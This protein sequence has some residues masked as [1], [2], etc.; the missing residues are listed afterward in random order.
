MRKL[1]KN[2]KGAV[3]VM[4]TLLLVPSIL[5]SGTGVDIAR[6]YATRSIVEDANQ[7]AANSVLASY[8]ALL[9]DLY[10]LYGFLNDGNLNTDQ[11]V[12]WAIR[13]S[14]WDKGMGTFQTFY[15]SNPQPTVLTPAAG[16]NLGNVPVFR[17]QI[18]EYS[19]FRAPVIIAEL[20]MDK[21]DVFNKIQEDAKVIKKKMEVD[22]GVE[23]L[24]KYY[25]RIYNHIV[26]LEDGRV[27]EEAIMQD[28]SNTARSI[29]NRL[30]SMKHVKEQYKEAYDEYKAQ[31]AIYN[32]SDDEDERAQA[33]KRMDEL[34]KEMERLEME[35]GGYWTLIQ[36]DSKTLYEHCIKYEKELKHYLSEL[37]GLLNDCKTAEGKKEDLRKKVQEL[38]T[39][40]ESGKCSKTLQDGMM[41]PE[42]EAG[43]GLSMLERYEALLRYNIEDMGQ[44]MYDHDVPQV[45]ETLQTMQNAELADIL[46]TRYRN[47]NRDAFFPLLPPDSTDIFDQALSTSTE[48]RPHV[49]PNGKAFMRFGEFSEESQEFWNELKTIYDGEKGA[50]ADKKKL[51]NSV[52][53]IFKKAQS[54]FQEMLG[55]F[56]PEG[57]EYLPGAADSPSGAGSKFGTGDKWKNKDE[58]KKEMEKSLDSDFLGKLAN[59]I[60]EVGNKLLLVVYDTEMFSDYSTAGKEDDGYPEENMAGVRLSVDVNYY[61]QSE[62]EYLYNGNLADAVDNLK[63]VAGMMFLVR[64]VLD[65]VASF[66]ITE[67]NEI[68]NGVK[69]AL[70]WTGPFSI[71]AGEL[72]RLG[73]SIGEAAID[74]ARLRDRQQ[75]AVFKDDDTWKLSIRGLI[76]SATEAI[77]DDAVDAAFDIATTD[78]TGSNREGDEGITMGY[79]DYMRVF[80][81]LIPG[82]TLAVRTQNL[83]ELNVTNYKEKVQAVEDT[84][85]QKERYDLDK[86]ITGFS[87]TTSVEMQMLF[88]SMPFAQ[89]GI[90]DV[91]PPRTLTLTATDYRGY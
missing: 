82:D 79:R 29:Q 37:D 23:E 53:K 24:E 35:Y 61:F 69:T 77:S 49:M 21:M 83:V 50:G 40:L 14:D 39:S 78:D 15:G 8:E 66:T 19:K 20:L 76:K 33:R 59:T 4:V 30:A 51:E 70:A 90:N 58:G 3:T 2:C 31:E 74:V 71:L 18:E 17:R 13:G 5:V 62:L 42:T 80:L 26:E 6:I 9:Q 28:I 38:R 63:S 7:L 56:D 46:L 57:A 47:V 73:L 81:L 60:S 1:L 84:M 32:Y 16:Q 22:D 75:V 10:G 36:R 54:T 88:L 67:V 34:E 45:Y 68:V 52:A 91:V 72:A 65:Y 48:F 86:L 11:Y 64:F 43:D 44:A 41:E 87:L 27:Q 89:Q 25:K 12:Q 55:L 85:A